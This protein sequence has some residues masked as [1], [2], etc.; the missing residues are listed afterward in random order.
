MKKSGD[1][2]K[3]TP[4]GWESD[5]TFFGKAKDPNPIQGLKKKRK[6]NGYE[7]Q[8]QQ[9]KTSVVRGRLRFW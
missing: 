8:M 4:E 2:D 9:L 7:R 1:F 5:P 3:G 6:R